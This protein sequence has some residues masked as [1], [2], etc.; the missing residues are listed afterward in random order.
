MTHK[1]DGTWEL[2]I[3]ASWPTYVQLNVFG[4]DNYYYGDS[5]GDGVLDRLPPNTA[6]PNYLNLSAPPKPHLA[7][8][9]VVDDATMTWSLE[10]RGES[11]IGAITYALLLSIPLIT[12]ALAVVIFMWSFYGIKY[13]QWGVKPNKDHSSYFPILGSLGNKSTTNVKDATPFSEKVF[14]HHKHQDIIGWPEDKDKRRTVL[15]ATLEYEIIDW[16]LKVK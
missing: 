16:K 6:A 5:D 13:N 3:M 10:P 7:W 11:I 1:D 9:L 14:G 4:F 2:E 15:I 12:G 8:A